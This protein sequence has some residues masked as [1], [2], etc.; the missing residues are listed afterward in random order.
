MGTYSAYFSGPWNGTGATFQVGAL[1]DISTSF[2]TDQADPPVNSPLPPSPPLSTVIASLTTAPQTVRAWPTDGVH[3]HADEP[4][5]ETGQSH[6]CERRGRD[7]DRSRLAT[8]GAVAEV[9]AQGKEDDRGWT[10]HQ[11]A[12][13]LQ[14]ELVRARLIATRAGDLYARSI[15]RRLHGIADDPDQAVARH[16]P[17]PVQ[18]HTV[19]AVQRRRHAPDACTDQRMSC[20]LFEPYADR[21]AQFAAGRVAA[22]E[23]RGNR[24]EIDVP[25]PATELSEISPISW[26]TSSRQI[27]SPRPLPSIVECSSRDKRKKGSKTRSMASAGMPGPES[28]TITDQKSASDLPVT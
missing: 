19:V 2:T 10:E 3:T 20:Y 7:R 11:A 28:E 21:D 15:L 1:G 26:A 6:S 8:H 14:R 16:R 13:N 23:V 22:V 17:I 24:T 25:S 12:G 18:T 5:Q 27:A 4:K 9:H